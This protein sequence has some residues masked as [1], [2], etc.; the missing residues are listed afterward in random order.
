[1]PMPR[2]AASAVL[3]VLTIVLAA[4]ADPRS[5][6]TPTAVPTETVTA[7]ATSSTFPMTVT[8]SAGASVTLAGPAK[9]IVS[10]SPGATEILF[11]IGAGAQVLAADEF[12]NYPAAAQALR[13]VKYSDPSPE[14]EVA[15]QPDLVIL[16]TNQKAAVEPFR[17]LGLPVLFNQEPDSLAG[18]LAN[19]RLLGRLTGHTGEA[20]EL[21]TRMQRRMDA[22]ASKVAD[23]RE[24]IGR[25]HV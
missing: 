13:K 12:S 21:A 1:M 9:R 3:A 14:A 25:A 8:D 19:V 10:H 7:T 2:C 20:E 18:V 6:A 24:E 15:L 4:C 11:A 23:V 17:R 16:A 22:V 5:S